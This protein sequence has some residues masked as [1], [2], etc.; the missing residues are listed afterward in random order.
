M[1]ADPAPGGSIATVVVYDPMFYLDWTYEI[2]EAR[3]GARGVTLVVPR[4]RVEALAALPTADLVV[5]HDGPFGAEQMA[6]LRPR[7]AGLV[8]YSVGMN[9]VVLAD[10]A[11]RGIPVRNLPTWATESVSDHTI[12]MLLAAQRRVVAMDHESRGADWDVR[13]LMK[14]IGIRQY[15]GQ[16]V[17]IIGAGRIGKRVGEKARGIG[18]RTIATDP[19]LD[20]SGDPDLPLVPFDE[21]LAAS[22][23]VVVCCSLNET[24]E[25]LLD[26]EAFGQM[27][28]G[29]IVVNCARGRIVDE[30]ALAAALRSGIVAIAALDV[31]AKEPPDPADDPITGL[32]NVILSPHIA[33]VSA[34]G[35]VAYHEECASVA[36]EMLE[37]AGRIGSHPA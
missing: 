24:S 7:I 1:G 30:H 11:A 20:A 19:F 3:L 14:G 12:T 18:F 9:Q 33:W 28:R 35:F 21:L 34:E 31:R 23:A 13:R 17:G 16:V 32:P 4:T 22:D 25:R 2:E 5:V 26:S 15:R 29:T 6:S 36:L 27:R 37:Q 10:A 8:C